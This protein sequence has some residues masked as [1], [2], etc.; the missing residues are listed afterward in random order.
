MN[1]NA[2]RRIG[3]VSQSVKDWLGI[4]GGT[5]IQDVAVVAIGTDL[6]E[7]P[8]GTRRRFSAS[9][10]VAA[11]AA[12]TGFFLL[13]GGADLD[14]V[15]DKIRVTSVAAAV[16]RV[17]VATGAD[18]NQRTGVVVEPDSKYGNN[19]P[20]ELAVQNALDA[21]AAASVEWIV[22]QSPTLANTRTVMDAALPIVLRKGMDLIAVRRA[23]GLVISASANN[24]TYYVD[25]GGYFD[26]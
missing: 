5:P 24:Q 7:P 25:V 10:T 1:L 23:S 11:G 26:P 20:L 6:R 15:V 19:N 21:A 16:M 4:G 14:V 13:Y 22:D 3:D 8:Y 9:V 2:A 12:N 17:Y 18:Y